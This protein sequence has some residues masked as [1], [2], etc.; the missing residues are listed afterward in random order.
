MSAADLGY[1]PLVP[2]DPAGAHGAETEAL[3]RTVSEVLAAAKAQLPYTSAEDSADGRQRL[4]MIPI[5]AAADMT[6]IQQQCL[7]RWPEN[8]FALLATRAPTAVPDGHGK[9]QLSTS[10]ACRLSVYYTSLAGENNA[11]ASKRLPLWL[12]EGCGRF[13][14]LVIVLLGLYYAAVPVRE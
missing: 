9:T 2:A 6:R 14:L 12:G 3:D 7:I 5:L 1:R 13:L 11:G 4:Y 10:M 8:T